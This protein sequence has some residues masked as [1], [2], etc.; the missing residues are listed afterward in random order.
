MTINLLHE[1]QSEYAFNSELE[2]KEPEK[3]QSNKQVY[4]HKRKQ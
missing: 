4:F 3:K 1:D 2:T